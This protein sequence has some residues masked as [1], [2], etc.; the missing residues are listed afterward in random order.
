MYYSSF[1]QSLK[2]FGIVSSFP[3]YAFV[4]HYKHKPAGGTRS[5]ARNGSDLTDMAGPPQAHLYL[6]CEHHA[7]WQLH[8]SLSS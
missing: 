6:Y 3:R 7:F 8:S 1:I 2:R 4:L 5:K